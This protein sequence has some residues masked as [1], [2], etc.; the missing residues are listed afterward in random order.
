MIPIT[1]SGGWRDVIAGKMLTAKRMGGK[2]YW[3]R[4]SGAW[5]CGKAEDGSGKRGEIRTDWVISLSEFPGLPTCSVKYTEYF[6][7][8]ISDS[9][10]NDVRRAGHNQLAGADYPAGP[11][12]RRIS[13]EFP[14]G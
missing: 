9:I 3:A 2:G 6:D 4:L 13:G 7:T 10:W 8:I 11:A 5:V 14:H 12:H 1:G